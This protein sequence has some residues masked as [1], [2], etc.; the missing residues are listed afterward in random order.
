M[1]A[2]H[3]TGIDSP[4]Q[5]LVRQGLGMSLA[6]SSSGW[7]H[8]TFKPQFFRLTFQ[9][10]SEKP[11][12]TKK[13]I[14]CAVL[15]HSVMFDSLGPRELQPTWLLCPG[16]SPG[17]NTRVGCH[18]LLQGIFPIQ[19]SNPA[20]LH[21]RQTFTDL[22]LYQLRS[23]LTEPPGKPRNTETPHFNEK[24][25]LYCRAKETGSGYL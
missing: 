1:I 11:Q 24:V 5:K 25:T 23:L 16:D 14:L 17:K 3:S 8:R 18:A 2:K 7:Q 6:W 22:V 15:S 13:I 4:K 9:E 19:G 12:F 20:L 21:C 10:I